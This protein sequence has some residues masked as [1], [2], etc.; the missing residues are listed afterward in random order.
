MWCPQCKKAERHISG[1]MIMD[2]GTF[3]LVQQQQHSTHIKAPWHLGMSAAGASGNG[4]SKH[5]MDGLA[6][7]SHK[8]DVD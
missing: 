6:S 3:N 2:E 1:M 8:M 5:S 4:T 7:T